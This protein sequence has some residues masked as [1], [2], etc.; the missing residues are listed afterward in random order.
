MIKQ[1]KIITVVILVC[2]CAFF[3]YKNVNNKQQTDIYPIDLE[4]EKC[5]SKN[6]MTEDMNKC[7]QKGI[8]FWNNEIESYS[9]Q[10]QQITDKENA[11]NFKVVQNN[12]Y[13]FYNKEK[14]FLTSTISEKDGDINKT[15]VQNDI[16]EIT[17]QRALSLKRY[18]YQMKY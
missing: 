14:E 1:I 3:T 8:D 5:S 4:I 18:L 9:K 7:I 6:Y 15:L 16:Y 11:K 17:K 10:I 12:W 13:N 2:V